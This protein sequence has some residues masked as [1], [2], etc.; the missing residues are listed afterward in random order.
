MNVTEAE[1]RRRRWRPESGRWS[2]KREKTFPSESQ[3]TFRLVFPLD[4][5]SS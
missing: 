2:G 3:F 5:H 4:D 1:A